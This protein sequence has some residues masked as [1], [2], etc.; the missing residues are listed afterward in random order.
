MLLYSSSLGRTAAVVRQRSNVD[1][2]SYLNACSVDGAYGGL[3][4]LAGTLDIGLHFAETKIV[5]YLCAILSS[6]LGSIGS[7]F[8][9]ATESHLTSRRPGNHLA[10]AVGE[11]DN[12]IVE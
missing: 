10:L 7:V 1:N 12:N 3:T 11:G 2:L 5:G 9:G 8:L 4:A 6:H